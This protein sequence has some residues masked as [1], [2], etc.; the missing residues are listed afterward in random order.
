MLSFM[1]KKVKA[2][3]KTKQKTTTTTTKLTFFSCFQSKLTI[4]FRHAQYQS[5]CRIF[6]VGLEI[7]VRNLLRRSNRSRTR[8]PVALRMN[9]IKVKLSSMIFSWPFKDASKN[10]SSFDYI[11]VSGWHLFN[12]SA[13]EKFDYYY[14]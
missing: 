2:T 4:L 3:M 1:G 6:A 13:R 7:L 14:T 5:G 10:E 8:S 12:S 11:H 9:P